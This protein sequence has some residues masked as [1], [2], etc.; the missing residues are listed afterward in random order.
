MSAFL[1]AVEEGDLEIV[2]RLVSEGADVKKTNF[3]GGYTP[4]LWAASLGHIP[5]M[6]WLLT[7]GGSSLAEQTTSGVHVW[8]LTAYRGNYATMQYMI[9]KHGGPLTEIGTRDDTVWSKLWVH[10]SG[11]EDAELSSLLKVMVMLD[12]SP[13]GFVDDVLLPQHADIC[14]WGRHFRAQLPSF[15]EQQRAAVAAHCPLPTVLQSIVTAY[16]V[17]TPEDMWADGLT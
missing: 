3:P 5:I 11:G 17:T 4:F 10:C 2:K 14:T 16:A 15:L 9:Q 8:L 12:D 7:E 1:D 13:D 6:H